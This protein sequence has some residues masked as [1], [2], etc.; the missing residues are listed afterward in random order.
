MMM[1]PAEV[2]AEAPAHWAV[3]FTVDDCAVATKL[4]AELGGEVLRPTT[5]IGIGKFAVLADP[6]GA[7]FDIMEFFE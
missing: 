2:P 5:E 3:Y 1:M 6:Q 7:T 4:A